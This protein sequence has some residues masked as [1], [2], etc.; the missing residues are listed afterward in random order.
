[1]LIAA[2]AIQ[3][4]GGGGIIVLPNI[5][6]SD[7]FSMRTRGMYFGILGMVWAVASAIGPI[8]GGV[9]TE[10]VSWRWCFYINLPLSGVGFFILLFFLKL[11]NP[12]TPVKSGLKAIDWVGSLL[13]VGGVVMLLIGLEFGGST[14][15]WSSPTVICLVVFGLTLIV[16]F[17][18]YEWK[19]AAY[20][21]LPTHIY[22]YR[23]SI[24]AYFIAFL[25]AFT[26]MSG[27]YWLP[28]YF[29]GVLGA[30]SLLSGVYLLPFALSLSVVSSISGITI[31]K[32][33]NYLIPII[34][35]MFVMT[36]GFGLFTDLG[37]EVNWAKLIIFE[38]IAG[39]GVGPNFQ[40][41]LI[42][43]QTNVQPRDIGSATASFSFLRQMGTSISVAIGGVI[44][45]NEMAKQQAT[46]SGQL[47]PELASMLTGANAA[48]SVQVVG[49][50]RGHQGDVAKGAFWHS[51]QTMYIVYTCFAFT[52]FLI[53]LFIRQT[54]LK[55]EHAEHKTGLQTLR[56]RGER[57]KE[58]NAGGVAEEEKTVG[59]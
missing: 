26:F 45:N 28:L 10:K 57:A 9:F 50:L 13:I 37:T 44:F 23:N 2:R 5:C 30:S 22:K 3:G 34:F 38:I 6:V 18:L 19:V 4:I 32:T 56:T 1:M 59:N 21:I 16:V 52:G 7:L 47:P 51:L 24:A 25:H 46:L 31:K 33:G 12:R 20:P 53:S 55:K 41:P 49:Q 39:I 15:P 17:A 27:S 14:Y 11:H 29:Q 48:G 40:A 58:Q 43:L 8:L 54:T 42:A 35:G 36:L